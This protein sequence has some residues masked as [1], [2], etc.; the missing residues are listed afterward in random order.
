MGH[1]GPPATHIPV[2]QRWP[3]AHARPHAPQLRASIC[4]LV[5]IPPQFVVPA[6]HVTMIAT[7]APAAHISVAAHARPH[8]PQCARVVAVSTHAPAHAV[9]PIG[10]G[11]IVHAPDWQV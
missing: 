5:H 8:I 11:A 7:H 3:A 9:S 6:G 10:H 2:S 1:I 4:V